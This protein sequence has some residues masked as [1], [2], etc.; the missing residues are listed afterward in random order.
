MTSLFLSSYL[1]A[2]VAFLLAAYLQQMTVRSAR[3]V[4]LSVCL[5]VSDCLSVSV[6]LCLSLSVSVCLCLSVSVCLCLSLSV[7]V[8]LCLSLST[9]G[10][11][12]RGLR[13]CR[14]LPQYQHVMILLHLQ[15]AR[16]IALRQCVHGCWRACARMACVRRVRAMHS[17]T[18]PTSGPTICKS[19]QRRRTQRWQEAR[20]RAARP[21]R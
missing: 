14:Q 12:G 8:C 16:R 19:H 17:T 11:R 9:G 4:C 3:S 18:G 13:A 7:S 5:S 2:S 1:S 10:A 6:R 15:S 20:A 21:A